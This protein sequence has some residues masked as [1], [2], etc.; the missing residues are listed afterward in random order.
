VRAPLA[1]ALVLLVVAAGC[2][3]SASE[4]K[5]DEARVERCTERLF[6][7]ARFDESSE[8]SREWTRRY[9]ERTYC[10]RFEREGWVYGD[11]ALRIDA[12]LWLE[13]G[14]AC[15]AA[16]AEPGGETRTVPC[17]ELD[18]GQGP[19]VLDCAILHH[20][21]R[22]EVRAYVAELKGDSRPVECDDGAPLD[23]LG[24]R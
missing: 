2:G 14:Y 8:A 15:A 19:P 17:A 4:S 23:E 3:S 5:T 24:V 10:A 16:T 13:S 1:S 12:H 21:R 22:S 7:R 9:I 6:E 20:V 11:G 18:E